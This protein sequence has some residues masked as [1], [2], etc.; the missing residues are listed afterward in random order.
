[1][2]L[3][4]SRAP[5]RLKPVELSGKPSRD[6]SAAVKGAK[7]QPVVLLVVLSLEK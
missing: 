4:S 2:F 7:Q 6:Y 5:A 1:M 3:C